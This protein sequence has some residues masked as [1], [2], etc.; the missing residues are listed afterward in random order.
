MSQAIS[1]LITDFSRVSI[2]ASD[3][4]AHS[5]RNTETEWPK[6]RLDRAILGEFPKLERRVN[7]ELYKL[8][9]EDFSTFARL[10]KL[11][12]SDSKIKSLHGLDVCPQ[13]RV[14]CCKNNQL[15]YL[16]GIEGC[17]KLVKLDCSGNFISNL[18]ALEACPRLT[19]LN[20]K[21]NQLR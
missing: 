16:G 21:R 1:D 19:K 7:R 4:N 14:L 3:D 5:S 8:S 18:K 10:T 20:C 11:D 2:T 17:P 13:L 6:S 15:V 12:C 9:L